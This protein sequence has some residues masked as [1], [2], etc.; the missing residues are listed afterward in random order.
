MF[1]LG[2][3]WV[4]SKRIFTVSKKPDMQEYKIMSQ[5]TG[6]GIIIIGVLAFIIMLIFQFIPF[7][8]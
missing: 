1:D 2:K 5:V 4:A 8:G 3:F 6:I 7:L